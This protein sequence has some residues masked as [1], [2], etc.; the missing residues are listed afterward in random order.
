M[1]TALERRSKQH[2]EG[3]TAVLLVNAC[4]PSK[5]IYTDASIVHRHQAFQLHPAKA[6]R[7]SL[8]AA[9]ADAA[10]HA[11]PAQRR[12]ALGRQRLRAQCA[13][14][15]R[16]RRGRAPR[17]RAPRLGVRQRGRDRLLQL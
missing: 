3:F 16:R 2:P 7:K 15:V 5:Y 13:H 17:A 1:A 14:R 12:Q 10:L 11:G 4:T 6:Q 8:R 9:P